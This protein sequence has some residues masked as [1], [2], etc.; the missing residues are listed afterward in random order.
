[1]HYTNRICYL[2]T[3][4]THTLEREKSFR[5]DFNRDPIEMDVGR[6]EDPVFKIAKEETSAGTHRGRGKTCRSSAAVN[7][8]IQIHTPTPLRTLSMTSAQTRLIVHL[9][10]VLWSVS[11]LCSAAMKTDRTGTEAAMRKDQD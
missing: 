2:F 7:K 6:V 10:N 5:I 11:T 4:T 8:Q 9:L 3:T 1:M